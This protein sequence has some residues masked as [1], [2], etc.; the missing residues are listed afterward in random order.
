M[1]KE[2]KK[3]LDDREIDL[4]KQVQTL[5]GE[6]NQIVGQI[7]AYQERLNEIS[8]QRNQLLGA[9]AN[10]QELKKLLNAQ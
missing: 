2:E 8:E 6:Y 5:D 9:I 3:I 1:T 10:T 4:S 7:N